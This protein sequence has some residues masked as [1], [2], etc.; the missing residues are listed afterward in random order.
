MAPHTLR[1]HGLRSGATASAWKSGSRYGP[2]SGLQALPCQAYG[3]KAVG[4]VEV[5]PGSRQRTVA[6]I[7]LAA[8]DVGI[9]ALDTHWHHRPWYQEA[10]APGYPRR[11]SRLK[12]H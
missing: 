1:L 4:L 2:I 7:V 12:G 8:D 11:H 6:E 5:W 3:R 10:G 9:H